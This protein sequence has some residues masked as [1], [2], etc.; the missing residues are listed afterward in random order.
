MGSILDDQRNAILTAIDEVEKAQSEGSEGKP[1]YSPREL[2]LVKTKLQEALLWLTE[3]Y[4]LPSE[5]RS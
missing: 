2:A 4:E 5:P 1:A 3:V